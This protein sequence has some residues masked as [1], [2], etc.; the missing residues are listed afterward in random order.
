MY[1]GASSRL[2]MTLGVV[3]SCAPYRA[4]VF[5]LQEARLLVAKAYRHTE[6]VLQDNLDKLHAVRLGAF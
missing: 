6:K 1:F 2:W 3:V 5:H 4:L